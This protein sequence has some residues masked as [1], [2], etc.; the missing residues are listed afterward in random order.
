MSI[1][2]QLKRD[3][4][5]VTTSVVVTEEDL[6]AAKSA[7]ERRADLGRRRDRRRTVAAVAAAVLVVGLGLTA[8]RT[9]TDHRAVVTPAGEGG[10]PQD[11]DT[12]FLKGA[13][14]T[15]ENL[16]GFWRVDNGKIMVRF[17]ADGT[18]EF[19]DQGT[20]VS[21]PSTI[22]AYEIDDH[23]ITVTAS[24]APACADP[25]WTMGAAL[26]R[27]GNVSV[28]LG[29]RTFGTCLQRATRFTLEQVVPT[30]S[31]LATMDFSDFKGWQTVTDQTLL[32]GDWMAEGGGY[33]LEIAPTGTYYVVG[34]TADV[35]DNGVWR[36]RHSNLELFSRTESPQCEEGDWFILGGLQRALPGTT[37]IRGT[38]EQNDCGGRWSS[39]RWIR[40]PDNS[41]SDTSGN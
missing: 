22:G 29:G 37:V 4:A 27:P 5:S 8:V 12:D 19:S 24:E 41:P 16:N 30:K 7:I 1:E 32:L 2:Q 10:L 9:L 26:P 21:D 40:M 35:V 18:V 31:V 11:F 14:P 36:F 20:I 15:P 17:Q 39:D 34:G 23:T 25:A 13:A 3:I 6:R 33:L 38:V 28:V